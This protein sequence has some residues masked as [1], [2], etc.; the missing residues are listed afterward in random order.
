L[1]RERMR[2]DITEAAEVVAAYVL[3]AE[4]ISDKEQ[5]ILELRET[6][7]TLPASAGRRLDALG[8]PPPPGCRAL[9]S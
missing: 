7:G 9:E 1:F 3:A 2:L 5:A 6:L 8:T 4:T